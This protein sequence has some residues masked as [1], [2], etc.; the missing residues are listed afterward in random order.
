MWVGVV[1]DGKGVPLGSFF[2][3]SV[4]N[5]LDVS[6]DISVLFFFRTKLRMTWSVLSVSMV[7]SAS[8]SDNMA[9]RSEPITRVMITISRVVVGIVV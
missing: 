3:I 5:L 7:A 4:D 8:R 2:T 9:A 6:T 1:Y